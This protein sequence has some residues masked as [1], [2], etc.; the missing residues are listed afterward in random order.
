MLHRHCH[1]NAT[2]LK[3]LLEASRDEA[4]RY[5]SHLTKE[6]DRANRAENTSRATGRDNNDLSRKLSAAQEREEALLKREEVLLDQIASLRQMLESAQERPQEPQETP[7]EA[8]RRSRL[9]TRRSRAAEACLARAWG[10]PGRDAAANCAAV[11][12]AVMALPLESFDATIELGQD[13]NRDRAWRVNG[14]ILSGLSPDQPGYIPPHST[15]EEFLARRYG[16]THQEMDELGRLIDQNFR[17][18]S[19]NGHDQEDPETLVWARLYT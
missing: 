3:D 11:A 10:A 19:K 7:E 2:N 9:E 15:E 12:Q 13:A 8:A 18:R 17:K 16:I 6:I 4:G 14:K 5:Y 1:Q